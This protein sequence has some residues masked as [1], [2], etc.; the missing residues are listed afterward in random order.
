MRLYTTHS[1]AFAVCLEHNGQLVGDWVVWVCALSAM[2]P[3]M[4]NEPC[5]TMLQH[6]M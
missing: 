6:D 2:V 4:V 5:C 1:H 3:G